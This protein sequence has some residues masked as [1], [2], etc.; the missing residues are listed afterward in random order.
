MG[1]VTG[2]WRAGGS[3]G[4]CERCQAGAHVGDQLVADAHER[5]PE[6]VLTAVA[7]V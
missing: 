5:E 7:A 4:G 3:G 2:D 6:Q 1:W